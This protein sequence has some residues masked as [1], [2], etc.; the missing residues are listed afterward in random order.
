MASREERVDSYLIDEEVTVAGTTA[1][2]VFDKT[3]GWLKGKGAKIEQQ[4]RPLLIK[5]SHGSWLW[6]G[7]ESE[8]SKKSFEFV[9]TQRDGDVLLRTIVYGPVN[10]YYGVNEVKRNWLPIVES[11][12]AELGVK[13]TPQIKQSLYDPTGLVKEI[14]KGYRNMYLGVMI[15]AILFV[16]VLLFSVFVYDLQNYATFFVCI[17]FFTGYGGYSTAK[18]A[19]KRLS[20]V[21]LPPEMAIPKAST[22]KKLLLSTLVVIVLCSATLVYAITNPL[23]VTYTGY[24]FT[25]QYPIRLVA[26]ETPLGDLP[27]NDDAGGLTL[28]SRDGDESIVIAW[29]T[30]PTNQDTDQMMAS[31][32]RNIEGLDS[33]PVVGTRSTLT[34]DGYTI[35]LQYFTFTQSGKEVDCVAGVWFDSSKNRMYIVNVIGDGGVDY[36]FKPWFES[37]KTTS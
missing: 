22:N 36:L 12:W 5:A 24:G 15:G 25:F 4:N 14:E 19:K 27:V 37:F 35:K 8:K 23:Y 33:N 6:V 30:N 28:G 10:T 32:I 1:E 26:T 16:G 34:K 11:L 29:V 31:I 17:P 13:E 2:T 20:G 3:L 21:T 9:F 18:N 7:G